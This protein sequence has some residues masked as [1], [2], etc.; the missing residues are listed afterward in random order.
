MILVAGVVGQRSEYHTVAWYVL[1]Q[2]GF[3]GTVAYSVDRDHDV[4]NG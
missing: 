4:H 2:I 1:V 3:E